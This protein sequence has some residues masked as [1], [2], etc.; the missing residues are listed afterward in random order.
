MFTSN[1]VCQKIRL[2]MDL[3]QKLAELELNIKLLLESKAIEIY[4]E[5]SGKEHEFKSFKILLELLKGDSE[6]GKF[7]Q[8]N[9]DQL[10]SFRNFRN[11]FIHGN[12]YQCFKEGQL[13]ENPN[14]H[15]NVS[16]DEIS[17]ITTNDKNIRNLIVN[18][19]NPDALQ[20]Q[21]DETDRLNKEIQELIHDYL[22]NTQGA[23]P[24]FFSC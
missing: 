22:N 10:E 3:N 15:M 20:K 5:Y 1:N 2:M 21:V 14:F 17:P 6:L 13:I 23:S 19:I 12:L 7:E 16:T 4:R 9:R 8:K 11:A 18:F 24:G